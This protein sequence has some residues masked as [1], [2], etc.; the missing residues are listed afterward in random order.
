MQNSVW[1][2]SF[3]MIV[4]RCSQNSSQLDMDINSWNQGSRFREKKN[5]S[6]IIELS[7]HF[8]H[9][10]I[11]TVKFHSLLS[12]AIDQKI[13]SVNACKHIAFTEKNVAAI[14]KRIAQ[15]QVWKFIQELPSIKS[16]SWGNL[17]L[18]RF[19]LNSGL[20][21]AYDSSV[22]LLTRVRSSA[23]ATRV[24]VLLVY[25][26]WYYFAKIQSPTAWQGCHLLK[27]VKVTS[28]Q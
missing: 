5:R 28:S 4:C 9:T 26:V 23:R 16:E 27:R 24:L 8:W 15:C 25:H 22:N 18:A 20:H 3:Y 14:F 1:N 2:V 21:Y 19:L 17:P 6:L 13:L 7:S 11:F 12:L 10:K